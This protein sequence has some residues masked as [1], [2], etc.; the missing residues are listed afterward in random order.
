MGNVLC[1]SPDQSV[2]LFIGIPLLV[3]ASG[4]YATV[5]STSVVL[6]GKASARSVQFLQSTRFFFFRFRA[7]T[8]W[9]GCTMMT[10]SLLL[11]LLPVLAADVPR[12]QMLSAIG[13]FAIAGALQVRF[14]PWKV[15]ILNAIDAVVTFLIALTILTAGAFLPQVQ[16]D[17]EEAHTFAIAAMLICL[18]SSISIVFFM[19]ASAFFWQGTNS[20][21]HPIFLLRRA[22]N[23]QLIVLKLCALGESILSLVAESLAERTGSLPFYD[24]ESLEVALSVMDELGI[25]NTP[26]LPKLRR[27]VHMPVASSGGKQD[28]QPRPDAE[29]LKTVSKAKQDCRTLTGTKTT[30]AALSTNW[31]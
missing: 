24:L 20:N 15:P 18:Y 12:V 26:A 25:P 30:E 28:S 11:S 8:W 10:R 22:P 14:W 23:D 21:V 9:W 29:G 5:I 3:C 1:G 17:E 16:G 31:V 19:C 6:P 27:R 7:D 4:F 2:M 13:L